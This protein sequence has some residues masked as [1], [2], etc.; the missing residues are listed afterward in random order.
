MSTLADTL[1]AV[2]DARPARM[3]CAVAKL[4]PQL[5]EA[6]RAALLQVLA[7]D[8]VMAS[9]VSQ[10]LA[11]HGHHLP[12]ITIRRH[13]RRLHGEGCSCPADA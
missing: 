13:R 9:R 10:W 3:K 6:D 7:D 12:A 2:Y 4:L 1:G 11:E 8:N 5:E